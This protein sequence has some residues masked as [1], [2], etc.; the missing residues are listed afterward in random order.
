MANAIR[1]ITVEQG[2]DPRRCTLMPFGGAGPL[3][4][5]LLAAELEI[6]EIVVPPVAGNFSAWGL[7]GADLVR[8][9]SRTRIARLDDE[10]VGGANDPLAELFGGSPSA[11]GARTASANRPRHALRRQEH[12][13]T[14]PRR[15]RRP[16]HGDAAGLR[17][18]SRAT[19]SAPSV[20]RWRRRRDRRDPGDVAP[21]AAAGARPP[22]RGGGAA[23]SAPSTCGRS[24][25]ASACRSPS[26]SGRPRGGRDVAGP[27]ILLE[28]TATTYLDAGWVA[29][30]HP[31]GSLFIREEAEPCIP[32]PSST[33]PARA[34]RA[35]PS[36]PTR[37]RPR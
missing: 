34:G 31:S 14:V 32:T 2:E 20:T 17:D 36:T 19:T 9:A 24:S 4:G 28:D 5:T 15:R 8:T 7:L 18:L 27:A 21:A 1:E 33:G 12:F 3:F 37:S 6:G 13:L 35:V 26:W 23:P 11:G 16:H 22:R 29:S 30:V 10:A 25:A